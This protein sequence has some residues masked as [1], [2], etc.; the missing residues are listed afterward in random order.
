ML[1]NLS[2]HP[3]SQWSEKQ[4]QVATE[5]FGEVVDLPFPLVDPKATAKQVKLLSVDYFSRVLDLFEK[6]D[7]KPKKNAVHIQGEFTF[8]FH[9]VT[10]LKAKN[11]KCV[12]STSVRNTKQVGN[13]K[14]INFNFVQFRE[15]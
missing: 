12:A 1:I 13:K 7:N 6:S 9:L 8:V 5:N 10:M 2:N 4:K 11:I 15:Y 3:Y 14:I